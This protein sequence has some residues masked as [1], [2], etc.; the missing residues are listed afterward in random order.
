MYSKAYNRAGHSQYRSFPGLRS[1]ASH[2][3]T[4]P[5]RRHYRVV[6]ARPQLPSLLHTGTG[7]FCVQGAGAAL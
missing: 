1:P 5:D 6:A 7:L 2:V 3:G 4:T